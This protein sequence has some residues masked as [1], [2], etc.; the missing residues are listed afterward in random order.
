MCGIA[1][2][3]SFDGER[4]AE[5]LRTTAEGM[6]ARLV[7]RGPD[8][9]GTWV[10][11]PAGV[12]LG[13]RRLRIIDLTKA[14]AQ[15][16][17]SASGRYVIVFN[18]EVYNFERLREELQRADAA[19]AWRGHS[20]TEVMLACFETWGVQKAV[21]R[22]IGMFAFAVW[23]RHER[24]L[25]LGRDRAGVK[26]LYVAGEGKNL[27]FASQIDALAAHP[28]FMMAID[29]GAAGLYARLGYVPA[30]FS[31]AR[32]VQKIRPG[33]LL[34]V[35]EDG[36]RTEEQYW[37]P[38]NV[39]AS[40]A[41]F[42]GSEDEALVALDV[43]FQD[44]VSLRMI[45]DVPVGIFLSGG[46]DSALVAAMAQRGTSTPV[47]T[48]TIGFD[49]RQLDESDAAA[50]VAAH[51]ATCH[52]EL[53]VDERALLDAVPL[54]PQIYDE[55]LADTSAIPTYL[56][57]R[58]ARPH[59]TVALSG[60]GGDEL[61]GG[62]HRYFLGRKMWRPIERVPRPLRKPLGLVL[63]AAGF[64]SER[65][66]RYG[67]AFR[68]RDAIAF[69]AAALLDERL[70][71]S[72]D[73][74]LPFVLNQRSEWP[75]LRDVTELQMYLDFASY[76]PD[77]IL[78]KVDRA[79]MAVSLESREPLLDH[80][81]IN[82]AWSLPVSMKVRDH[83]GKWILRR[84]LQ[85]YVPESLI[86]A[87]KRGFGLPIAHWLRTALRD[88]VE[89]NLPRDDDYFDRLAVQSLWKRHLAGQNH[90]AL[91]WRVVMFEA[92]RRARAL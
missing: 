72:G 19:P 45:A 25:I 6:A 37:S 79:T 4:S 46:V 63:G 50:R 28:D 81:L 87:E 57:A 58:L 10:D 88:W 26:P 1:G 78:M 5:S 62:Y 29:R 17:T 89:A 3:V 90:D 2:F 27:L 69:H 24:A 30:P 7:H 23:D 31:I 59:V 13:F 77:D 20:D 61:F 8:D 11:P 83:T 43:L 80:R 86:G 47:K 33:A 65:I 41:V 16:M 38:A 49:D 91:I 74:A 70:P 73:P 36:T 40:T 22:F 52:E 34:V 76:L 64:A 12:A 55:P 9:E 39:A 67:A 92:W 51:L 85:R 68:A 21:G 54:M 35:K 32:G 75:R 44:A 48:F 56:V 18:G 14:G 82:F 53:R 84:L 71:I 42:Q 66:R 15:P 60:D